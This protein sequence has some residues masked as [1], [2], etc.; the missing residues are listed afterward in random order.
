MC[1][2][3]RSSSAQNLR[4][5]SIVEMLP[6]EKEG[7]EHE[8]DEKEE[9]G[10]QP[11]PRR[12]SGAEWTQEQFITPTGSF[13]RQRTGS[14]N[15]TTV[16]EAPGM[17]QAFSPLDDPLEEL[18]ELLR[19]TGGLAPTYSRRTSVA[20][21]SPIHSPVG[22]SEEMWE[23]SG[24][25]ATPQPIPLDA[26]GH[27]P[28]DS[29][30]EYDEEVSTVPLDK[31][32]VKND[33]KGRSVGE[34]K[35]EEGRE[36]EERERKE[37]EGE[38]EEEE[39]RERETE[40]SKAGERSEED[41]VPH[42]TPHTTLP[43]RAD[44]AFLTLNDSAPASMPAPAG[45]NGRKEE[46][47]ID[48]TPPLSNEKR[49]SSVQDIL[50]TRRAMRSRNIAAAT[51][52][53]RGRRRGR[54]QR[55][56]TDMVGDGGDVGVGG[57]ERVGEEGEDS[58]WTE[59]QMHLRSLLMGMLTKDPLQRITLSVSGERERGT[60]RMAIHVHTHTHRTSRITSGFST[61]SNFQKH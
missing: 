48:T 58:I 32:G 37:R 3:G 31:M 24:I 57:G 22:H 59:S 12:K 39:E 43:S 53:G 46:M 36:K 21:L 56:S 23:S 25:P 47:L 55:A 54:L 19:G 6:T 40:K 38:R 50:A 9:E 28:R 15:V 20:T 45:N 1:V 4:S 7:G 27:T 5:N 60:M 42:S 11:I 34:A 41:P 35:K 30:S 44:L 49:A 16:L 14:G 10:R 61:T 17:A 26:E 51:P 13:I 29:S 2:A 8:G 52:H 18:E 33:G